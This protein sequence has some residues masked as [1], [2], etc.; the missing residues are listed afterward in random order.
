[1]LLQFRLCAVAL[2][3]SLAGAANAADLPQYAPAAAWVKPIALPKPKAEGGSATQLLLWN[4]QSRYSDA[5]DETFSEIA[6][7]IESSEALADNGTLIHSWSPDTETLTV[8]KMH[9]IRNG[10]V[11]DLLAGGK[12]PTVVRRERKLEAAALDGRL[13]ATLAIEDLRVG[14]IVNVAATV[15]RTDPVLAGRSENGTRADPGQTAR[16][17]FVRQLWPRAEAIRWKASADLGQPTLTA[18]A[19]TT[20]LVYDFTDRTAPDPPM[21][22]PDRYRYV[23]L[24]QLSEFTQWSEVADVM[25][26][27]YAQAA[28]LKPDSPLKAEIERIR[29]A[30]PDAAGRAMAALRLVQD[31]VRYL[32]VGMD[33]GNYTPAAADATWSRR[34]GDCKGKTALLLALLE[35]L[36]VP[37]TAALVSVDGGDGLDERLPMLAWFDHVLVRAEIDGQVHWLDGTRSGDRRLGAL[38]VPDYHWALPVVAKTA[39]LERL[40]PRPLDTPEDELTLTV[41]ASKG[42][43]QPALLRAE[44]TFRGDDAIGSNL[45]ISKLPKAEADKYMRAYWLDEYPWLKIKTVG[46]SYEEAAQVAR[47]TVQGE[48]ELPWSDSGR[49]R[50]WLIGDSSLGW[51]TSF[52]REPGTD[53]TAPFAVGHPHHDRSLVTITLPDKGA[54]AIL[55]NRGDVDEVVAGYAMKRTARLNDGVARIEVITRSV[56]PEFAASEA[57]AAEARLLQLSQRPIVVRLTPASPIAAERAVATPAAPAEAPTEAAGFARQGAAHLVKGDYKAAIAD[58]SRAIDLDPKSARYLYERGVARLRDDQEQAAAAD[59]DAALKLDPKN[60]LALLA[61]GQ[62]RLLAGQEAAAAADFDSAVAL[63][64]DPTQLLD[65]IGRAYEREGRFDL[66]VKRYDG[67]IAAATTDQDKAVALN[68]R[69]WARA[70]WGREL[71]AALADCDESLR[72]RPQTAATLDSRGL[73]QLRRDRAA[74]AIADYDKALDLQPAMAM[75]LYGR[76][77]AKTRSGNPAAGAQDRAAAVAVAPEVAEVYAKMGLKP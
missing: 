61:R 8:H 59:F 65:R 75:S 42:V 29:K 28:A 24:L 18:T 60:G 9:V 20:E 46:F 44:R 62:L 27:L 51:K 41:D 10:A 45:A 66:A 77:L 25:A 68:R 30:H 38:P 57:S 56:A 49:N 15:L 58:L 31:Q 54:N 74:A 73:V 4:T 69:C 7:R 17:V 14:D 26:P 63:A 16:R 13:T 36:G 22:A 11:I 72:L 52:T 1:M 34:Y 5:G 23:S 6:T 12:R 43:E 3:L 55:L 50:D 48:A 76:G 35:G 2:A 32:Y 53:Q 64:S 33:Y 47:L 40:T 70:Q 67:W 37:A 71:D 19:D 21:G 39:Q